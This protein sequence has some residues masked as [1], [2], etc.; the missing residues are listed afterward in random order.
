MTLKSSLFALPNRARK[1]PD[2]RKERGQTARVRLVNV[3]VPDYTAPPGV[4]LSRPSPVYNPFFYLTYE[5]AKRRRQ[6]RMLFFI[7]HKVFSKPLQAGKTFPLLLLYSPAWAWRVKF[8]KHG[9]NMEKSMH[10]G[11]GCT[12]SLHWKKEAPKA[13]RPKC[14]YTRLNKNSHCGKV[15]GSPIAQLEDCLK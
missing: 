13:V 6:G 9:L 14:L 8:I 15:K 1:E 5:L 2:D 11:D 12:Q 4:P 7:Q 10:H 3:G